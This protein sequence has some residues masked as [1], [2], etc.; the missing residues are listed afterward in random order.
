MGILTSVRARNFKCF[1]DLPSISLNQGTYFVGP[2]NAGKTAVLQAINCFFDSSAY[3]P[4]YLN[5]TELSRR[6]SGFNRSDI[7]LTFDLTLVTGRVRHDRMI[8]RYGNQLEITKSFTWRE[9][10]DSVLITY[11]VNDETTEFEGLD[12][13]IKHLL[14]SIAISYIHPQEGAELLRKAQEKFKKRLFHNWGRHSSV[15]DRLASVQ[16]S[17]NELRNTANAYLSRTLTERLRDIWPNSD[18]KIDLPS[19]LEDI[20]AISGIAFRSSPNLPEINLTSHGTGAQSTI[21][22]Q[23]HYV[24]D[25]DRSLHQGMYFPVWLLEEPESFL[26]ADIA[27]QLGRLL[28]SAE[29]QSSIQMIISTHSPII[30]A[31]SRQNPETKKWVL[32]DKYEVTANHSVD[33][34]LESDI[35]NIGRVMGD[36]NFDAYFTGGGQGP[37]VFIE[38]ARNVTRTSFE[39]AG[40]GVTKSL[41]GIS[42]I[43]KY[44]GVYLGVSEA[45]SDNAYFIVDGDKGLSEVNS[46]L[47]EGTVVDE[48][49]GWKK[50]KLKDRLF[51]I[52]LPPGTA[53]ESLFDEWP[54]VLEETI[55]DL[56]NE[57]LSIKANIP[58]RLSRV[59]EPL[60]R[61]PPV[62]RQDAIAKICSMQ[63]VKDRFWQRVADSGWSI[64]DRHAEALRALLID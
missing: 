37:F 12:E 19:R 26:H 8:G 38:D 60:R 28:A 10:S 17:W 18:V 30:L 57:D 25:S 2:N 31:G 5:R 33:G 56:L 34:V 36:A 45:L 49:I 53:V 50:Y 1:R 23:T 44:L 43:K 40:I 35:K 47:A 51:V 4:T 59:V 6:Q 63:D 48:W 62:D 3:S 9:Q 11:S 55:D 46:L 16:E 13:D 14:G 52:V 64:A 61:S 32:I 24:L 15:S 58:A 21:L 27:F 54:D 22:Y 42:D 39:N 7:T 29:W 20:V 41:N